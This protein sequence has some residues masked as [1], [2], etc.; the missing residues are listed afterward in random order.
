MN[1]YFMSKIRLLI[2]A[3]PGIMR[4]SLVAYLR[5][6]SEIEEVRLTDKF[7]GADQLVL[8]YI[9]DKIILDADGTERNAIEFIQWLQAEKP[10]IKRIALADSVSQMHL[11]LSAGA[12]CAFL[13]GLLDD[14]LYE[15]VLT[16]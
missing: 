6:Y 2:I 8:K 5:P 11:L 4:N 15:A 3:K 1:G 13:K 10:A 7:T 9:P 14:S 16:S 12:N